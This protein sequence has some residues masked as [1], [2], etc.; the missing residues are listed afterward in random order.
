VVRWLP[1]VVQ[2]ACRTRNS[3]GRRW[4]AVVALATTRSL[5]RYAKC[6]MH[7]VDGVRVGR[8]HVLSPGGCVRYGWRVGLGEWDGWRERAELKGAYC[9]GLRRRFAGCGL[10][11]TA[12]AVRAV[13]VMVE[14]QCGCGGVDE[15][16]SGR[17]GVRK[18]FEC[19]PAGRPV[20]AA[21]AG[22]GPREHA[23]SRLSAVS[24]TRGCIHAARPREPSTCASCH[25]P[26]ASHDCC[27]SSCW[28]MQ[29]S[30][31]TVSQDDGDNLGYC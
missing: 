1:Y 24:K 7:R 20:R 3:G 27:C 11:T 14:S 10:L 13:A 22:F 2:R 30:S 17:F 21:S 23:F 12:D 16:R 28:H 5:S 15:R 4:S 26:T 25:R 18:S 19:H 6:F 31:G 9:D 29:A 8:M